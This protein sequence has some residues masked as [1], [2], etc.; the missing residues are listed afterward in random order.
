[1]LLPI[2]GTVNVNTDQVGGVDTE[3]MLV[4]YGPK[5]AAP[6][7]VDPTH[8]LPVTAVPPAPASF[9]RLQAAS[10]LNAAVVKNA[11]GLFLGVCLTNNVTSNRY[12]KV[13]DKANTPSPS[14]T[15]KF[16]LCLSGGA[17]FVPDETPEGGIAFTNGIAIM[18]TAGA[19]ADADNT[20]CAANDLM[21]Y[22]LYR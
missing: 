19:G 4:A 13:Y 3:V 9:L 6:N 15:P 16:A 21:G 10:G 1:M 20:G 18:M 8:P 2:A 5:G 17:A 7:V 14:D 22:L 12:L 11:P